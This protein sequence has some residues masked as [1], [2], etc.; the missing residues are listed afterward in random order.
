MA[1]YEID[2]PEELVA[3]I[4][5][6]NG[7]GHTDVQGYITTQ[8]TRPLIDEYRNHLQKLRLSQVN[9]EIRTDVEAKQKA[10]KLSKK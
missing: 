9:A 2:L 3:F 1:K 6:P 8:L 7:L 10:I 5:N 4:T